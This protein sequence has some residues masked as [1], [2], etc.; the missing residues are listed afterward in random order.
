MCTETPGDWV[1][2]TLI[3]QVWDGAWD[4]ASPAA[5]KGDADSADPATSLWAAKAGVCTFADLF[6][7][8]IPS[9]VGYMKSDQMTEHLYDG[10][11]L[12]SGLLNFLFFLAEYSFYVCNCS[13]SYLK[14]REF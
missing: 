11:F 9:H 5:S 6:L 4:A 3:Q 13:N 12:V 14:F 7:C 1:K 10:H 2:G 8:P